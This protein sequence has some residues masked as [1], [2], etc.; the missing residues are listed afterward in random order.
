MD[1]K[2][3]INDL[4]AGTRAEAGNRAETGTRAEAGTRGQAGT[5]AEAGN[6][7]E[8]G[9]HGAREATTASSRDQSMTL[10]FFWTL[11]PFFVFQVLWLTW[12]LFIVYLFVC[13]FLCLKRH[14][15]SCWELSWF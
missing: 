13:S 15:S 2:K 12:D 3:T 5:Q 14:Y 7:A 6:R 9:T 4:E 8:A 1:A 10:S 11:G